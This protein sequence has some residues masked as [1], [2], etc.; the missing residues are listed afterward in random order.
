[1]NHICPILD[2]PTPTQATSFRREQWQIVQCRETGFT[3][4][5]NPPQYEQLQQEYAW[6]KTYESEKQRRQETE[7][8]ITLASDVA[9]EIKYRISPKRNRIADIAVHSIRS[10]ESQALRMLDIG[11]GSGDLMVEIQKRFASIGK[12]IQPVGIEVSDELSRR[13][14]QR[15]APL[16][17][18]IVQT[19]AIEGCRD[20]ADERFDLVIMSCFLEHESKPLQLLKTVREILTEHGIVVIK[21]PN[22]A[23]WNRRIRGERWCGFRF[24]DHVNYFTPATLRRVALEAGFPPPEQSWL[25]RFPLNDNMYA[26]L[27]K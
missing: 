24:P 25:D 14:A 23:S 12:Q 3:F 15:I 27:R 22:F 11:C 18:K 20:L 10:T 2:R 26:V 21:V 16:G 1:M 19:Y 8:A 7:P 13:A 17:G 9:K 6:E 5:A 4:L